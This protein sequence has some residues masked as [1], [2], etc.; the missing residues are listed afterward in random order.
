MT[1]EQYQEF[2]SRTLNP[3]LNIQDRIIEACFG[4]TGESGE[5]IDHV[6]KHLFHKH[7]INKTYIEKE[8][9][10]ILW[11]ISSLASVLNLSFQDIAEININKLYKR[12][13]TGFSEERSINRE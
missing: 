2:A 12:Y 5:L 10:D 1:F 7:E 3:N 13:P 4:I 8:I 11:Y 6:K 9:G